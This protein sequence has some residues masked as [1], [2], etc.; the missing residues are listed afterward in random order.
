MNSKPK[1]LLHRVLPLLNFE[2]RMANRN[3]WKCILKQMG[4]IASD[5]VRGPQPAYWDAETR[6]QCLEHVQRLDPK[7]FGVAVRTRVS[8]ARPAA[9]VAAAAK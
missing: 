1:S 4:I 9:R 3:L 6:R 5:R 2:L 7:N 8:R